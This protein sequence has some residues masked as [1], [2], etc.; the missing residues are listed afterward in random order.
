MKK[1]IK[2]E[3]PEKTVNEK[4]EKMKYKNCI[5]TILF[6]ILSGIIGST[7]YF[8]RYAILRKEKFDSAK[9][10]KTETDWEQHI[11]IIKKRKEWL[12][13]QETEKVSI[14]GF[15]G[16][17]LSGVL[18]LAKNPTKKV[19]L[20]VHGY[21]SC[22]KNDFAAIAPFYHSL[23]YHFLMIDHRAHGDS[24]GKYIGFGCLD[25]RDC[26]NWISYLNQR[27]GTE[28]SLIL[29]G[30]SM[31]ASTIMMMN[32][33]PLP[34]NIKGMIVDCGFTSVWEVFKHLLKRDYHLPAF[35]LLYTTSF[36][37]ELLAGYGF[38]DCSSLE[39]VK[40]AKIP[41]LFL[42]GEKD[43]FIPVEMAEK[44]YAACESTKKLVLIKNAGHAESYY[45]DPKTYENV[46]GDFLKLY[47]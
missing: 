24:E 11:Q 37:N 16:I 17:V 2:L 45:V 21:R 39:G 28:V 41:L 32:R 19:I 36:L 9:D 13:K 33:M 20:G 6:A 7:I 31:G 4:R 18:L 10:L 35:P 43:T 25:S 3:Y 34:K 47:S 27:F 5:F 26:M 40:K 8:F 46:V 12:E 22:G 30:I 14:L 23:G 29:H 42:H 38:S 1:N 15:D 44:L